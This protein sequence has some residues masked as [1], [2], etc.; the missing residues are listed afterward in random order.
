MFYQQKGALPALYKS[1]FLHLLLG[2]GIAEKMLHI[3][4]VL[5]ILTEADFVITY[6]YFFSRF[7]L[8]TFNY[9]I[10]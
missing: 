10:L 7:L 5:K 9:F 4:I 2:I 1:S 3:Q 8:I 6:K